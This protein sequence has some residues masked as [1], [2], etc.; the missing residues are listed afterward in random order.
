M[1]GIVI[2]NSKL[3]IYIKDGDYDKNINVSS[4]FFVAI[5]EGSTAI[6]AFVHHATG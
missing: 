4:K 6:T 3:A 5:H 1:L 2:S